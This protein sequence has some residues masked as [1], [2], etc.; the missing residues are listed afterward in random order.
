MLSPGWFPTS[1]EAGKEK[2]GKRG[3]GGKRRLEEGDKRGVDTFRSELER[4]RR[5]GKQ[6]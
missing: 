5:L 1:L 4:S 6:E 2:T 3:G